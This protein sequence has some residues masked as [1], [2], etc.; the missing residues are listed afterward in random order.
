MAV[1]IG[2]VARGLA[3]VPLKSAEVVV[4]LP[5]M[6][7]DLSAE[8]SRLLTRAGGLLDRTDNLLERAEAAMTV[9]EEMLPRVRRLEEQAA[10]VGDRG[11]EVAAAAADATTAAERQ[12]VR[13]QRL[14][15]LYQPVL[16]SLTP[17]ARESSRLLGPS[18]VRGLAALLAELPQLVDRFEP[19]LEGMANLT[20]ELHHVTDKV[21]NVGE[22]VEGVPGATALKR[23][24]RAREGGT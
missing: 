1:D 18:H 12:V 16:E 22:I 15:D 4:A 24:G 19:A 11:G 7:A 10:A 14:L 8:S 21:E 5:Q 9:I 23:R 20:P 2:G 17:L 3:A 13:V 6:A